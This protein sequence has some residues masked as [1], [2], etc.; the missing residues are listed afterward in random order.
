MHFNDEYHRLEKFGDFSIVSLAPRHNRV[1]RFS[2]YSFDKILR[3]KDDKELRSRREESNN[4]SVVFVLM[5]SSLPLNILFG[6]DAS[7]EVWSEAIDTWKRLI[8]HPDYQRHGQ[9]FAGVKVSHHGARGSLNPDLYKEY[10]RPHETV[11]IL[12]VGPGDKDHP[13]RAVLDVL[14][15]HG[16]Q[17]Y[18]T[19]W[20]KSREGGQRVPSCAAASRSPSRTRLRTLPSPAGLRLCRRPDHGIAERV[21]GSGS[22]G[23]PPAVRLEGPERNCEGRSKR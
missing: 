12:S 13:H 21:P 7:A 23:E 11:A 2:N 22:P 10:C 17:T 18:A 15:S 5:H 6:G 19:C 1:D 3:S 9:H 20:P 8:A 14:R 4:L 16:I